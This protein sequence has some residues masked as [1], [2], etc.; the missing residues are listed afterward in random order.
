[1]TDATPNLDAGAVRG[2]IGAAEF[3]VSMAQSAIVDKVAAGATFTEAQ[4]DAARELAGLLS[5]ANELRGRERLSADAVLLERAAELHERA[6]RVVERAD[7]LRILF[8]DDG[9]PAPALDVALDALVDA[10]LSVGEELTVDAPLDPD[11][12][13]WAAQR[14]AVA[15]EEGEGL[16]TELGNRAAS[17]RDAVTADDSLPAMFGLTPTAQRAHLALLRAAPER[18]N[19]AGRA[20][21]LAARRGR[22]VEL[23]AFSRPVEARVRIRDVWVDVV[24]LDEARRTYR[25]RVA[26]AP[27]GDP[28]APGTSDGELVN[29]IAGAAGLELADIAQ[30]RLARDAAEY[31]RRAIAAITA[32]R[33]SGRRGDP[34]DAG[35][36]AA[37]PDRVD[38]T[39]LMPYSHRPDSGPDL[40]DVLLD[41]QAEGWPVAMV[42]RDSLAAVCR[43]LDDDAQTGIDRLLSHH[44]EDEQAG[45]HVRALVEAWN[46]AALEHEARRLRDPAALR[47]AL[48]FAVQALSEQGRPANTAN[49]HATATKQLVSR[50]DVGSAI[51]DLETDGLLEREDP[52]AA[53]PVWQMTAEGRALV[54]AP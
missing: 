27:A 24:L 38:T 35:R 19:A 53:R 28:T 20:L 6:D 50:D 33:N 51:I 25:V 44:T 54:D 34:N 48:L 11:D 47:Y 36:L 23:E 52:L 15:L 3:H 29:A 46:A 22:L 2:V 21:Q 1:M 43:V 37:I 16:F 17:W 14:L 18:L 32:F 4:R 7:E 12:L 39:I 13:L 49:L 8:D 30:R 5:E 40:V 26:G 31:A 42:L 9:P 10:V 41:L 45:A